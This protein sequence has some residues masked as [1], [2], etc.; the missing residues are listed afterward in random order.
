MCLKFSM[1]RGEGIMFQ[2][3]LGRID[4]F[5]CSNSYVWYNPPAF[6]SRM[7]PLYIYL[8]VTFSLQLQCNDPCSRARLSLDFFFPPT[9]W[10][11][12]K[13]DTKYCSTTCAVVLLYVDPGT[14]QDLHIIPPPPP[15]LFSSVRPTFS[16]IFHYSRYFLPQPSLFFSLLTQ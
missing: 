7:K 16:G 4:S 15:P 11:D 1:W 13:L 3:T 14:N 5:L 2:L 6:Q 9:N 8:T 12:Y 10:R